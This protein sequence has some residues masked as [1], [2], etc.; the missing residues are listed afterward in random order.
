MNMLK[1][2]SLYILR[3]R[4]KTLLL[5][6]LCFVMMLLSL[7][8]IA[9]AQASEAAAV[10]LRA[11]LGGYLHITQDGQSQQARQITDAFVDQV[12]D[13]PGVKACNATDYLD[14]QLP[15]IDLLPGQN[16]G[17]A[18]TRHVTTLV[19]DT[20]SRQDSSFLYENVRLVEGRHI[21][22]EDRNKALVSRELAAQNQ[23]G[24]GDIIQGAHFEQ[25]A[26]ARIKPFATTS[27]EIVGIY[28]VVQDVQNRTQMLQ[29][30]IPGNYIY[31]DTFTTGQ[32]R[33]DYQNW[34]GMRRYS[35]GVTLFV[36]DPLQ[37]DAVAQHIRAHQD[38][39]GLVLTINDQAYSAAARPLK[40]I[41]GIMRALVVIVLAVCAVLLTL[42]LALWIRN[43]RHEMGIY[44][45]IGVRKGGVLGQLLAECL[46][47]ALVAFLLAFPAAGLLSDGAVQVVYALGAQPQTQQLAAD[48][49]LVVQDADV[50]EGAALRVN[51]GFG[52]FAGVA[53]IGLV[54]VALSVCISAIGV[55]RMRPKEV[56]STMS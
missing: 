47:V 34:D 5:L 40:S 49:A 48:N 51:V 27:F 8:G 11:S 3:Q 37:M 50:A 54:I 2:A 33:R 55:L 28:E 23:L 10:R 13:A 45:S 35:H 42:I 52:V 9:I 38:L 30:D 26:Q 31:T 29:W 56:L 4:G 46:A 16:A 44:L 12:Q 36:T 19:S 6:L 17:D 21:E 43:R 18:V 7:L 14:I 41:Q 20:S 15:D 24:V 39:T 32:M 53:G 22:P 1:R 25:T